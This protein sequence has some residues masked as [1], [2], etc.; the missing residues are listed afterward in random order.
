M[1]KGSLVIDQS[2]PGGRILGADISRWQ[3]VSDA[4][5]DFAKMYSVGTRF[6]L[7]KA[8]DTHDA[9]DLSATKYFAIDRVAAQAA[10]LYTGLYH[11]AYLPDTTDQTAIIADAKAQAEKAIWRLASV[12]GYTANDLPYTLDLENKC[13][14]IKPDGNCAKYASRANTTLFAL[15]WLTTVQART[16]RAPMLY[17]YP[18]FLEGAIVRD[19]AF[20]N[21]PLWIAHYSVNPND[22][23]ANPGQRTPGCY[24]TPWT[25]NDCTA[26][27]A[28]WQFT[29]CGSG[30]KYGVSS[31]RLDLNVFRGGSDVFLALTKGTW[32]PQPGDF[33]PVNE[34]TT[35]KISDLISTTTDSPV[36]MK[37]DVVRANG[38]P[39]VAGNVSAT[40][41]PSLTQLPISAL[42]ITQSPVRTASGTWSLS[43]SGLAAGTWNATID[44]KDPTGVHAPS[45]TP[46]T[47]ALTQGVKPVPTPTPTTSPTPTPSPTPSPTPTPKPTPKPT[48]PN[49]CLTQFPY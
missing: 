27:W 13:A 42:L 25:Q 30:A 40:I 3:H 45:S 19:P 38:L 22:P 10:G 16:G 26:Q 29:S 4:P 43:V 5:I 39:V 31:S 1:P 18:S 36:T 11:Y 8:S 14:S 28:V 17:S 48:P 21:F 41:L 32:T 47:F 34:P 2:G 7:I 46:I 49:A 37:V 12:G 44:F 23:L 15:T 33:L 35:I 24:V 20:R 6:V 9:A